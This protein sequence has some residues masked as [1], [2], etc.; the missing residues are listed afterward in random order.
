M[1]RLPFNPDK[2]SAAR[3]A[4]AKATPH[5][6]RPIRVS[7]L[8]SQI[9]SALKTNLPASIKVQ[10][11]LSGL[12]HQTHLY[13]TLKDAEAAISAVM[14]A[15]AL[16]KL[17]FKP[18]EGDEVIATGRIDFWTRAGRTQLYIDK[19]EPAGEGQL[20]AKLRAL[21][22][23]LRSEGYLD[24]NHKQHIPPIPRRIAVI[25]SA[26][27]AALQDVLDTT[28]R[29][30]PAID[31]LTID[32]RVQ[33]E[34]AAPQISNAINALSNSKDQLGIDTIILTRGGG[35]IEDLW[36]FNERQVADAIHNASIPIIAAIGHETDTTLAELVA[37][38][39]AATPTQA[40]MLAIPDRQDLIQQLDHLAARLQST[41]ERTINA[42]RRH[43]N[44]LTTRPT[45]NSPRA[46]IA[47][48]SHALTQQSNH[49]NIATERALNNRLR[50][51][52]RL[53]ARLNRH[54]PEAAYARREARL[55]NAS[56]RLNRTTARFL[57][58]SQHTHTF[59]AF[60]DAATTTLDNTRSRFN[61]LA[62]ELEIAS[63]LRILARG[64]S[65][66]TTTDGSV[67]T[68][69]SQTTT[70]Q[71]ITTR[72]AKGSITSTVSKDSKQ[73]QAPEQAPTPAP[74]PKRAPKLKPRKRTRTRDDPNQLGLF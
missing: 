37:D 16:R 21:T 9:A 57:A 72:L 41:T 47:P 2:A 44:Q 62:R 31:I 61:A 48:L 26:T 71:T 67:I 15:P 50:H 40:A 19:L 63:P 38:H 12:K 52:D 5:A 39:R 70:G 25:T 14:F 60:D 53:A 35:S 51:L 11:E 29:R 64:F 33:G 8:A 59:N 24:P 56:H 17:T 1:S 66:T 30:C 36:A 74:L 65:V 54:R 7:D 22:E 4:P 23:Q 18:A 46:T 58:R 43:L 34:H 45:L 42:E 20:L 32:A 28:R 10:G 6:Q 3:K 68:S 69:P 27:S 13:C 49:I 55:Q 73:T